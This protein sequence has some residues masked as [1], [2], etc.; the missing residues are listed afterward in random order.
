MNLLVVKQWLNSNTG[1]EQNALILRRLVYLSLQLK[2][3]LPWHKALFDCS[4][5]I[6]HWSV[7]RESKI[8]RSP[9]YRQHT[10]TDMWENN[11]LSKLKTIRIADY[12]SKKSWS[13]TTWWEKTF[14]R[15]KHISA[16]CDI[17]RTSAVC[18][19]TCNETKEF[20]A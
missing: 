10:Q 5:L 20:N 4:W 9:D 8:I 3:Y 11:R 18:K 13:H 17:S 12:Q 1:V 6:C 7:R 14:R 16:V 15:M 2:N 19:I